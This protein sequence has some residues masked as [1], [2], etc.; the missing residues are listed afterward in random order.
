MAKKPLTYTLHMGGKQ[1][2]RLTDEQLDRLAAK[3]SRVMSE[4]YSTRPEEYAKIKI[5]KKEDKPEDKKE[6]K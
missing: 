5:G 3:L 6:D 4:Y 1:I 2:D